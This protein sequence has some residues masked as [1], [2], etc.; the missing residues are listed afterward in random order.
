MSLCADVKDDDDLVHVDGH[1]AVAQL[2]QGTGSDS[3][4]CSIIISICVLVSIY[5]YWT[6]VESNRNLV[7]LFR[8]SMNRHHIS[9]EE[10]SMR[11][12]A[13]ISLYIFCP[14]NAS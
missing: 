7:I 6:S 13:R 5:L 14:T 8:I 12:C 9:Y 1:G 2:A 4:F 11:N 10:I 3:G